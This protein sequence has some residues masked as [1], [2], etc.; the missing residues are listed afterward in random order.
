[1]IK[2]LH[3]RD[4]VAQRIFLIYSLIKY[5]EHWAEKINISIS[6]FPHGIF[7][8]FVACVL[9][10]VRWDSFSVTEYFRPAA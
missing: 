6:W 3:K 9:R 7:P 4:G 2:Y 10:V 5:T 1:M 8:W